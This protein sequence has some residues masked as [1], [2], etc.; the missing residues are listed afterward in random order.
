ML[1][2][3]CFVIIS[4]AP[5]NYQKKSKR[6]A[7]FPLL[8]AQIHLIYKKLSNINICRPLFCLQKHAPQTFSQFRARESVRE[9]IHYI[10]YLVSV[11]QIACIAQTRHYIAAL[12]ELRIDG[13]TV[14]L[15]LVG[16]EQP[17]QVFDAFLRCYHASHD[18]AA[19]LALGEE[20]LVCQRHTLAGGKHGVNEYEGASVESGSCYILDVH[21]DI[22]ALAVGVVAVG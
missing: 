21:V 16:G 3:V 8:Y 9:S 6:D 2:I 7:L 15:H 20:S 10:L 18:E 4:F 22:V 19:G 12:V 11:H 17:L 14:E 13:C 1:V 5:R